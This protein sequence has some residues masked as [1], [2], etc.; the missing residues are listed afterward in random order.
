MSHNTIRSIA[1][2][3]A[4]GATVVATAVA[5]DIWQI[6]R[7]RAQFQTLTHAEIDPEIAALDAE[8][9]ARHEK[10]VAELRTTRAYAR[11]VAAVWAAESR[12]RRAV[13]ATARP[14]RR[15]ASR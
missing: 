5:V 11:H 3:V 13:A 6:R 15:F 4:A 1:T 12:V 7:A 14:F 8:L 9:A 2:G 10:T